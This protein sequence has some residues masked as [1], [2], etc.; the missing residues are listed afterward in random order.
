MLK[1]QDIET[2]VGRAVGGD[3]IQVTHKPTG[4]SRSSGPPLNT[5]GKTK[6]KMLLE[7]EFELIEKGLNQHLLPL[8]KAKQ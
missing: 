8:K 6:Q 3:F 5:P 2:M 1:Q 4:I 7:I